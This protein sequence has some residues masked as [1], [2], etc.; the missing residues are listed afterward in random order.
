MK[1]ICLC[2]SSSALAYDYH[3]LKQYFVLFFFPSYC[4]TG[5]SVKPHL[6]NI[7]ALTQREATI[8][9]VH[10]AITKHPSISVQVNY[11]PSKIARLMTKRKTRPCEKAVF[12]QM[13]SNNSSSER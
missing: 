2:H 5:T 10:V 7:A 3:H 12:N 9:V 8:V 4:Q 6:V 13:R 11:Y 1:L